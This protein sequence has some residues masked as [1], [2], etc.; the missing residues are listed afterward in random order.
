[1]VLTLSH[2][3]KATAPSGHAKYDGVAVVGSTLVFAPLNAEH[4]GIFDSVTHDYSNTTIDG[5]NLGA[6][7]GR[8]KFR[9]AAAHSDRVY[10]APANADSIGIFHV[11]TR[12]FSTLP[13]F[14][15][16]PEKYSGAAASSATN[17]LYFGPYN[18]RNVGVLDVS[19][20]PPVFSTLPLPAALLTNADRVH[21]RFLGAVATH[22]GHH[23]V[24]P[25][26]NAEDVLLLNTRTQQFTAIRHSG[27]RAILGSAK[28][29]GGAAVGN[30]VFLAPFNTNKIGIV[31]VSTSTYSEGPNAFRGSLAKYSGAASFNNKVY[32]S[33]YYQDNVGVLDATT[34]QFEFI[35]TRPAGATSLAAFCGAITLGEQ[36]FFAPRDLDAVG[37]LSPSPPPSPP[38]HPPPLPLIPPP[39][40]PLPPPSPQQAPPPLPPSYLWVILTSMLCVFGLIAVCGGLC[41]VCRAYRIRKLREER[42]RRHLV[43]GG[44]RSR[45]RPSGR[46]L[47]DPTEMGDSAEPEPSEPSPTDSNSGGGGGGGGSSCRGG[48]GPFFSFGPSPSKTHSAAADAAAERMRAAMEGTSIVEESAEGDEDKDAGDDDGEPTPK[49]RYEDASLQPSPLRR[50]LRPSPS[51]GSTSATPPGVMP[52]PPSRPSPHGPRP[53][54]LARV[55]GG[56]AMQTPEKLAAAPS[57]L[58][59]QVVPEWRSPQRSAGAT[60]PG[61]STRVAC[62]TA[63]TSA[64]PAPATP[65]NRLP[66]HGGQRARVTLEEDV[67]DEDGADEE[68]ALTPPEDKREAESSDSEDDGFEEISPSKLVQIPA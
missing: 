63:A 58:G 52:S 32:F 30:R 3:G 66:V 7:R 10:F 19:V 4:V 2:F 56:S 46:V 38:P 35:P 12:T 44:V 39:P 42:I 37:I 59:E 21:N 34:L 29:S 28:F 18:E 11:P 6:I 49:V 43:K 31:D 22:N 36:V 50:V 25:P 23:I 20:T 40:P 41:T 62:H 26:Y 53:S 1:M 14:N 57:P 48:M 33:P 17:K 64:A 15:G 65:L 8:F 54:P 5:V 16:S 47:I 51:G 13:I 55:L 24:F 61:S 9:G 27:G 60:T 68:A 45:T 67:D